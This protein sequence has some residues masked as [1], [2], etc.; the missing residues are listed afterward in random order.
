MSKSLKALCCMRVGDRTLLNVGV[1]QAPAVPE[2]YLEFFD[3]V[4]HI[5]PGEHPGCLRQVG[6]REYI[7]NLVRPSFDITGVIDSLS[8]PETS[9]FIE[10]A[11]Q[12]G[13][14][15]HGLACPN[16]A[17]IIG[18]MCDLHHLDNPLT[19]AL[20]LLEVAEFGCLVF[21]S[22][23]HYITLFSS[24][25]PCFYLPTDIDLSQW[26]P[27]DDVDQWLTRPVRLHLDGKPLSSLHPTRSYL[28]NTL[29]A[30]FGHQIILPDCKQ[31]S[32]DDW[33]V[34]LGESQIVVQCGLNGN[35]HPPFLAAMAKGS[36]PL[37]D[38]LSSWTLSRILGVNLSHLT[39]R[40][41]SHLAALLQLSPRYLYDYSAVVD[42]STSIRHLMQ[43]YIS[44]WF[45]F[46]ECSLQKSS[47][48]SCSGPMTV[49]P[50]IAFTSSHHME[51]QQSLVFLQAFQELIRRC[52]YLSRGVLPSVVLYQPELLTHSAVSAPRSFF[53]V[54]DHALSLWPVQLG[55]SLSLDSSYYRSITIDEALA[56]LAFKLK[57][58]RFVHLFQVDSND[59]TASIRVRTPW[60]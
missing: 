48:S 37:I 11:L 36:I 23:P 25:L 17:L 4:I 40:S 42:I 56:I 47:G 21:S 2:Y 29:Y 9:V 16:D 46:L 50:R 27:A 45:N 33:L 7:F 18:R 35:A 13:I 53:D 22:C 43:R 3:T 41:P 59:F 19:Q 28:I 10:I 34:R 32:R 60:T 26:E 58:R 55:N 20:S 5:C 52:S 1:N 31:R 38:S 51:L 12:S 6:T 14:S 57:R 49:Q 15:Y 30:S 8:L 39:Y 54:C 44:D 24:L